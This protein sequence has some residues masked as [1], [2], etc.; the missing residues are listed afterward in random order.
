MRIFKQ[1][2][3]STVEQLSGWTSDYEFLK[4]NKY[5]QEL[6]VGASAPHNFINHL[7][8]AGTLLQLIYIK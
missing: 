2:L 5:D 7:L 3:N 4:L 1:R 8:T 6:C